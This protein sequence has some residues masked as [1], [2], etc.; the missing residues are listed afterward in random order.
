MSDWWKKSQDEAEQRRKEQERMAE[1]NRQKLVSATQSV[2]NFLKGTANKISELPKETEKYFEPVPDKVRVRDFVRELPGS[3][4]KVGK[5]IG[6]FLVDVL[7][8]MPRAAGQFT[9]TAE[10]EKEFVPGTGVAPKLEK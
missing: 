9:L 3:T 5:G 10:G 2:G 4:E 7:R 8:A 6:K 1:E